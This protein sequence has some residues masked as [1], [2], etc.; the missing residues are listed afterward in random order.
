LVPDFF[1]MILTYHIFDKEKHQ[2]HTSASPSK[3]RS[4]LPPGLA[5]SMV[6]AIA[7]QSSK[8]KCS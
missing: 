4:R 8:R 2:Y 1:V 5:N 3:P 6:L 7:S